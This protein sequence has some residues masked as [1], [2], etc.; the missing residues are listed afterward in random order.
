MRLGQVHVKAVHDTVTPCVL[1]EFGGMSVLAP[2]DESDPF[3]AGSVHPLR[4]AMS[5]ERYD[6]IVVARHVTTSG[7]CLW[8]KLWRPN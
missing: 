2:A 4:E 5:K 7:V 3:V 8:L 1:R 6:V